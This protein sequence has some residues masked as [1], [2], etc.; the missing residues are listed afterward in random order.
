MRDDNP[1]VFSRTK[2]KMID[3]DVLRVNFHTLLNWPYQIV[4]ESH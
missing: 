2:I 4:V 3:P 1:R